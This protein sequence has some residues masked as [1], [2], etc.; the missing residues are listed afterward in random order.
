MEDSSKAKTLE[1]SLNDEVNRIKGIMSDTGVLQKVVQVL[2]KEKILDKIRAIQGLSTLLKTNV[3]LIPG[4]L[5]EGE[6]I[7][8]FC[9]RI[10]DLKTTLESSDLVS[11][12]KAPLF[13]DGVKGLRKLSPQTINH[14]YDISSDLNENIE[15]IGK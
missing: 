14:V 7:E 6:L 8:I 11:E 5:E 9:G 15:K 3:S 4:F 1:D 2:G 12:T 10:E 13:P